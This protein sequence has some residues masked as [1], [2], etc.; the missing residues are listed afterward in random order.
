VIHSFRRVD[1][2]GPIAARQDEIKKKY[3]DEANV[4]FDFGSAIFTGLSS[5]RGSYSELATNYSFNGYGDIK[6]Y[7]KE[8]SSTF[9]PKPLT[10]NKFLVMLKEAVGKTY[11]GWK[12]GDF[13]MGKNT[14]CGSPTTGTRTTQQSLV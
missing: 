14:P 11:Q 5:W 8:L 4:R 7:K 10:V 12:G 9:E 1:S 3:N 13:V 6:G 2:L